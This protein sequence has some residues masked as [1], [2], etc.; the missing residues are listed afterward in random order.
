[1]PSLTKRESPA[2][3]W[4]HFCKTKRIAIDLSLLWQ[5]ATCAMNMRDNLLV[6]VFGLVVVTFGCVD[7][8]QG[9]PG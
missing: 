3:V 7:G 9:T 6:L 1:M 5:K 2:Q 8:L 4:R